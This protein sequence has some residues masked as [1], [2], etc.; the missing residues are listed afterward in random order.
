MSIISATVPDFIPVLIGPEP[1]PERRVVVKGRQDARTRAALERRVKVHELEVV[2]EEVL[3]TL[4]LHGEDLA[5]GA[6][7]VEAGDAG[8]AQH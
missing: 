7:A 2:L 1:R 6:S 3:Q 4:A 5:I 8:K